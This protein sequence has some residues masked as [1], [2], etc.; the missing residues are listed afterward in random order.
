MGKKRVC[1]VGGGP[2]DLAA[3]VEGARLGLSIDLFERG[4]IGMRFHRGLM[5]GQWTN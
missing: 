5:T 3:A 1:V 4:E 2:A